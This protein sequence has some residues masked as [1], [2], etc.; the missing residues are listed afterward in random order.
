MSDCCF[1]RRLVWLWALTLAGLVA[2]CS[3]TKVDWAG[4][5]GVYTYDQ[6]V[7]DL[8]PPDKSATLKDGTIVAEWLA[9]RAYSHVPYP[10]PAPYY[11]G[12]PGRRYYPYHPPAYYYDTYPAYER[13]LRLTFD[14]QGVLAAWKYITK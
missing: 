7:I 2:G 6:A 5:I 14:P 13:H 11:Y 3:T 10:W 9:Y 1:P 8:G 12:H 4:R